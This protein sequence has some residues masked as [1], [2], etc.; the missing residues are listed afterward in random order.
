M[1][2]CWPFLHTYLDDIDAIDP[3]RLKTIGDIVGV[4]LWRF[5]NADDV[6]EA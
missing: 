5:A 4:A 2:I 3:N 1:R 6:R